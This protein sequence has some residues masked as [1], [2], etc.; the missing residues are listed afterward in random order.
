MKLS[1]LKTYYI[2]LLLTFT[3][4]FAPINLWAGM[5]VPGEWR[6]QIAGQ[7]YNRT[8]RLPVAIIIKKPLPFE[9][10]PLN[11]YIGAGDPNK[12]IGHIYLSSAQQFNTTRGPVTLQYLSIAIRG[13]RLQGRL[14]D[15][16]SGES[17]VL[18]GFNGPNVSAEEASELMKGI[19]QQAWGP[20]EM[21]RFFVGTTIVLNF[22]GNT[23]SGSVQ[24][25]G[26]SYTGTSSSVRYTARIVATRIR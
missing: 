26:G 1:D 23:L 8:F 2:I 21:F 6:G 15:D 18:N 7:V 10:N 17:A 22:D 14:T 13:S 9:N 16:H 5:P 19:L 4:F 20:T 25:E 24:G 11:I 3:Y 12:D